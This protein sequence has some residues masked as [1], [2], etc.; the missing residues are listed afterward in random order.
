MEVISNE[1]Q[2]LLAQF[3]RSPLWRRLAAALVRR[4]KIDLHRVCLLAQH[5]LK[6]APLLQISNAQLVL[7]NNNVMDFWTAWIIGHHYPLI[8]SFFQ[9]NI[10]KFN[11]SYFT[12]IAQYI[13][14]SNPV[15]FF[16]CRSIFFE[17][18]TY[19]FSK[20]RRVL[21]HSQKGGGA[22]IRKNPLRNYGMFPAYCRAAEEI[23][24]NV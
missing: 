19:N 17:F 11:I 14:I 21:T 9:W 18:F 24:A 5:V 13:I 15:R 7:T 20:G 22:K 2:I 23:K 12:C 3:L 16:F 1:T 6:I 4:S 10:F 8:R